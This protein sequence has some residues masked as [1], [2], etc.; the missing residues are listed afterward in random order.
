MPCDPRLLYFYMNS[1]Q[2]SL[3]TE[4][5]VYSLG[6]L[7][8]LYMA[9]LSK[10]ELLFAHRDS[11]QGIPYNSLKQERKKESKGEE[12]SVREKTMEGTY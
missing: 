5:V 7:V 12:E 4:I 9:N 10:K 1:S 3:F 11:N 2:T 6:Q 8:C